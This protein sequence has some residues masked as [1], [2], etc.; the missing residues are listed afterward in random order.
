MHERFRIR[1]SSF[2][3]CEVATCC[4]CCAL[5]QVATHIKSYKPGSYSFGP[6]DTLLGFQ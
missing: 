4:S 5:A 6:P 3:D 2:G 1:G